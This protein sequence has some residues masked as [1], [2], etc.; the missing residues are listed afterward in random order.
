MEII[1]STTTI[2]ISTSFGFFLGSYWM[3]LIMY[4]SE[5]KL[6]KKLES[7]KSILDTHLNKYEDD[8]Y[9]AC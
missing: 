4:K 9:E 8:D 6:A 7:T 5:Q 2:I 1:I 3:F